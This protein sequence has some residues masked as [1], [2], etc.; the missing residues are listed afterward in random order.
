MHF[1]L[2]AENLSLNARTLASSFKGDH[3]RTVKTNFYHTNINDGK[4]E[5]IWRPMDTSNRHWLEFTWRYPV[6][7]DKIKVHGKGY[8]KYETSYWNGKDWLKTPSSEVYTS[9]LRI[10]FTAK[11]N[12]LKI[13]E[14]EVTGPEQP[15]TPTKFPAA[16]AFADTPP[17][18]I[19]GVTIN[20]S[21]IKLSV[22]NAQNLKGTLLLDLVN[23]ATLN[24]WLGDFEVAAAA[25]TLPSGNSEITFELI[26]PEFAPT[27]K[28]PLHLRLLSADG[29]NFIHLTDQH[30]KELVQIGELEVQT[31]Q[32]IADINFTNA[33]IGTLRDQLGFR[34]ND[35]FHLPFFFRYMR[36]VTYEAMFNTA[37]SGIDIQYLLMYNRVLGLEKQWQTYFDRFDENI[38]ALLSVNPNC[39]IIA[40]MD[41]RPNPSWL[42]ANHKE[43]MLD[44]F[45]RKPSNIKG[46]PGMVSFGSSVY[47]QDCKK[48][49]N[50]FFEFIKDKEYVNR[51]IGYM[52]NVCTQLDS[53]IGGIDA[54]MM[55]NDRNKLTYGDW[56]P[57]AIAKF[58]DWLKT[59]YDNNIELL[60]QAWCRSDVTFENAMPTQRELWAMNADG[61]VFR[62]PKEHRAAIDYIEFF[63]SL[64]GN[65]NIELAGH[66]KQRAGRNVLTLIHYGAVF[67]TL[68]AAQPSG[69]R[70]HVQNYDLANLL[71]SDNIDMY[72]YAP[73][74][75]SRQAGDPYFMYLPLDSISLHNRLGMADN[76]ARTFSASGLFH[77]K[78]R[79]LA[80]TDSVLKRDIAFHVIKNGGAWLSDMGN[81]P[82][83]LWSDGDSPWFGRKEVVNIIDTTLNAMQSQKEYKRESAS[84][85]AVFVSLNTPRYEDPILAV[86]VYY[87]L[88]Y[89][90][91]WRELQLIG[92]P[93]DVYLTSDLNNPK[94][95]KDYKLYIFL[96]SFYLSPSERT[97]IEQ[98]KNNNKTL[99][100]FYAPGYIDDAKGL[101]LQS[102]KDVTGIDIAIKPGR[103]VPQLKINKTRHP[104]NG[105]TYAAPTYSDQHWSRM[106]P[107]EIA[108][109]FYVN[110]PKVD[111]LGVYDDGKT[112]MAVRDFGSWR[113]IYTAVPFL[114]TKAL[115]EIAREA[116]V[117]IYTNENIF[118]TADN[119]FIMFS[120]GYN[121][122]RNLT[123][124]IPR[125]AKVVDAVTGEILCEKASTFKLKLAAPQTRIIRLD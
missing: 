122:E 27:G 110:D 68:R 11:T 41:L 12:E 100:W 72:V 94:L 47:M 116:G 49:I 30:N 32:Q 38:R 16:N 75:H 71:R 66:I 67:A 88:I 123:I 95:K 65:F 86:P 26:I 33:S 54:N 45:G 111:K 14:V 4:L 40:A 50:H 90:M 119:R 25:A 118:M 101:S 79:G 8:S 70:L 93:Y 64:L 48:F 42:K 28:I 124:K 29:K 46:E 19:M 85:I 76:D 125:P 104:L 55:I 69:S 108:P 109:L 98:L 106:H 43:L 120:N 21:T 18:K 112:A 23:S 60:R 15:L 83:T 52:P 58:R 61:G 10:D 2:A 96:N 92:A 77:G 99:M 1:S 6:R 31:K 115:R 107:G 22:D 20:E 80:E 56:H 39:H 114:D 91:Y 37:S 78:H 44:A 117:N 13:A 103:E 73:N 87:N 102:M 5:T 62:D 9:R 35:Q 17:V 81:R 34:I 59:K 84:E 105:R 113:S 51:I 57:G 3:G 97:A 74:Y 121:K 63:P 53:H 24:F 36:S 7:I 82:N 89:R